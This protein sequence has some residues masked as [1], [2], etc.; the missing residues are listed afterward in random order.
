[1]SSP[2]YAL[3]SMGVAAAWLPIANAFSF[4]INSPPQQCSNLSISI[5]GTGGT[6]P[7]RVLILPF[8]GSPLPN[9]VEARKIVDQEFPG[10]ATSVSFQLKYPALSQFV[11]VV[12]DSANFGSGGTSSA[13]TVSESSDSSCYDSTTSVSPGFFYNLDPINQVVQCT[14]SR[15]WWTPSDVQG[16]PTFYGV[17]PGGDSFNITYTNTTTQTNEGVGFNWIPPVRGGTTLMVGAGDNRGLGAGGSVT[18]IV[19]AGN[20]VTSC[21]DSTS[22]SS[23]AG[24]P[25]GGSYP[26][27]TSEA[28]NG[29][30]SGGGGTNSGAIAGGVVAGVVVICAFIL[31]L[32]F[33][34]RRR[35][36]HKGQKERPDLFTDNEQP[37]GETSH[38]AVPEPY[39]VPVP[40]AHSEAGSSI[41]GTQY[42][43]GVG[44][45]AGAGTSALNH[46]RLSTFSQST[47]GDFL[48]RPTTPM[49]SIS[50]AGSSSAASRKGAAPPVL[51]PV[52][53]IQHEDAGAPPHDANEE[54]E[55]VELPPAYTNIRQGQ[56]S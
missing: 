16:S 15:V 54:P 17:I 34:R 53:F 14:S 12:S 42:G 35:R 22:P 31:A 27:T 20:E 44:N 43:Y 5:T 32:L 6:P 10:N 28:E 8:G 19:S 7:Y 2:L 41:P 55:T 49:T 26:T 18:Y 9:N 13:A 36:F 11:V 50:G 48:L 47:E 52:N 30:K 25:A 21:L 24:S 46:H 23:T 4:N 37:D 39:I 1:M 45:G 51:R 33:L 40:P 3:A 56:T 38:L 29:G